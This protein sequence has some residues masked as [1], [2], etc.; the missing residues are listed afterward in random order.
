MDISAELDAIDDLVF[1]DPWA[2]L[3]RS[4]EVA[5]KA[6][7]SVRA[8][9][10][11]G[12]NYR[13]V[14]RYWL[15][16]EVFER[17]AQLPATPFD[18]ADFLCRF[19]VLRYALQEWIDAVAKLEEAIELHG[20]PPGLVG[21]PDRG[22]PSI[23]AAK[24]LVLRVAAEAGHPAGSMTEAGQAY[25]AALDLLGDP[26]DAP[27]TYLAAVQGAA[28][29]SLKAGHLVMAQGS[30]WQ[31]RSH[32]RRLKI[33]RTTVVGAKVEWSC[34]VVD[35]ELWG[36]GPEQERTLLRVERTLNEKGVVLDALRAWLERVLFDLEKR[37][38][39]WKDIRKQA[40]GY[41]EKLDW[42]QTPTEV[43]SALGWLYQ[44]AR[45][46]KAPLKDLQLV[47]QAIGN[48]VRSPDERHGHGLWALPEIDAAAEAGVR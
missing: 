13:R 42:D 20:E 3:P 17:G 21:S 18:R 23:L 5:A 37:A 19:A 28:Y 25:R 1:E 26:D 30:L 10:T 36:Y 43:V 11:L 47:F 9:G 4:E 16:E 39:P 6:P 29:V 35:A 2:A 27:R 33:L 32:L 45:R 40:N 46:E 44:L 8:L 38:V 12:N 22:L 48:T 41:L 31:A 14:G 15:S 24:G 7:R 34:A